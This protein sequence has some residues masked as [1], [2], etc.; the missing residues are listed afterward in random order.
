M[1]ACLHNSPLSQKWALLRCLLVT[2]AV[3]FSLTSVDAEPFDPAHLYHHRSGPNED[4]IIIANNGIRV[5][6][7]RSVFLDPLNDLVTD[8]QPGDRC[9]IT[10]LDNDPLAQ[11]PGMLTPKKFPCSFGPDEVKYTHFGSRSPSKDRVKLQ[12]RYDS[13]TDTVHAG[14]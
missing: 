3:S 5:P 12:L 6:F 7:G 8:V 14:S 10:V 4:N 2:F 11:K 9:H 13:Q 1:A